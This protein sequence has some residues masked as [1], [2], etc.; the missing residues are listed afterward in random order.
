[1]S[2]PARWEKCLARP[3]AKLL[4]LI[5][6]P[7]RYG[8]FPG[9][10]RRR[11][12][13]AR[14]GP[15]D[16]RLAV[17]TGRLEAGREGYRLTAAVRTGLSTEETPQTRHRELVERLLIEPDGVIRPATANALE[18]PLGRHRDSLTPAQMEAGER[19]CRDHALSSLNPSVTRNWSADAG[20]RASG[21]A[22][23]PEEASL[24]RLAAKDRVMDA[25]GAV[26]PA[27]EPVIIAIL[28]RE[29][30]LAALE[31][32]FGWGTRS[33]KTVLRLA[34]DALARFYGY[35]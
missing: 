26:G 35:A 29:E 21:R 14:L 34:L 33:G 17:D 11:R 18:G 10:D 16:I 32:R 7:E 4:P 19:F 9:G 28:V 27:L 24:S 8:V 2:A 31:R 13:L 12:P 30:S 15:A 25:L 22:S 3:G 6:D 20:G 23:G 1:M 5:C